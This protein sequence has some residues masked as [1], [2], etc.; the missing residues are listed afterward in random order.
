MS[1]SYGVSP[2]EVARYICRR[3][4]TPI[5][6][7]G[8]WDKAVWRNA[9]H[10]PRFVDMVTGAPAMYDTRAAALWDDEYFYVAMWAEEPFVR[11]D[12]TT[13]DA[14]IFFENDLELFIDG[15][16]TYYELEVNA[17]G[18]LYEVFYIWRDAYARGGRFD[19][20]EFDVHCR[21]V[22]SFGG[23][24]P[25]DG[26]TFWKGA[27]PRGSRWAFLNWDMA[28]LRCAVHVDG[29]INDDSDVDRG[30]S[31]ELAIP[32]ASMAHL[33]NGRPLPPTDGDVWP[34]LFGRFQKL[35]VKG[36]EVHPHPGWVWNKHGVADTHL[37]E[38]FTRI[39]FSTQTAEQ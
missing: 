9:Q 14:L 5:D 35:E 39:H 17:L 22:H 33:A 34:M 26:E 21:D 16:D 23:D 13:R 29:T 4:P 30:W 11:A 2:D 36:V 31:I 27:H 18:T 8:R 32:W 38:S 24:H 6:I 37:P 7:D 15:G 20:D 10:S 1:T 12:I 28:G 3:T 19:T 25:H